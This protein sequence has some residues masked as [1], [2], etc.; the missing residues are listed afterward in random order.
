VQ[1]SPERLVP[2]KRV[3]LV[4]AYQRALP[5]YRVAACQLVCEAGTWMEA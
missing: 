1:E 5:A 2:E 3:R 4:A